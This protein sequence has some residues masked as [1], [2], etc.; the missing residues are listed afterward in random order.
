MYQLAAISPFVR[1]TYPVLQQHAGMAGISFGTASSNNRPVASAD[2]FDLSHQL[3][4]LLDEKPSDKALGHQLLDKLQSLYQ[5]CMEQ[6]H[7]DTLTGLYNRS[8]FEGVLNKNV[9]ALQQG[10]IKSLALIFFDLDRFGPINKTYGFQVGD[11]VLRRLGHML[12]LNIR[13]DN[14]DILARYGGEEFVLMFTDVNQTQAE[15]IACRLLNL[16]PQIRNQPTGRRLADEEAKEIDKL[17]DSRDI[18]GSLGLIHVDQE[19]LKRFQGEPTNVVF[20]ADAASNAAKNAGKNQL[21]KV[22]IPPDAGQDITYTFVKAGNSRPAL[23][24]IG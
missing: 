16:I 1:A 23:N 24:H 2:F 18:T 22:S 13:Q 17:F 20:H 9:N 5:T 15:A 11:E 8:H 10:E 6:S 3:H 19:Q 21:Y 4:Q 12:N 7:R 14:T